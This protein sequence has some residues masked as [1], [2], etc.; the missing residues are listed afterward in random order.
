MIIVMNNDPKMDVLFTC[1]DAL[2][3]L[4]GEDGGWVISQ[5]AN[6]LGIPKTMDVS[7]KPK[8]LA[9]RKLVDAEKPNGTSGVGDDDFAEAFAKAN[10]QTEDKKV[11]FAA[12]CLFGKNGP[13]DFK[14]LQVSKR[15]AVSGNAVNS[16]SVCLGRLRNQKP[17][18]VLQIGSTGN[19]KQSRKI[20]RL[21]EAGIKAAQQMLECPAEQ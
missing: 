13:Q 3:S 8:G 2:K 6:R 9:E 16:V 1:Y 17:A 11:L 20:Y 14:G 15:L 19:R 18:L 5:L 21:T 12:W 7:I 4:A 10:P